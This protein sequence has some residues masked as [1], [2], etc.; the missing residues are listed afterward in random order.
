MGVLVICR[1]P[2]GIPLAPCGV[3]LGSLGRLGTPWGLCWGGWSLRAPWAPH[4]NAFGAPWDP[5]RDPQ[6]PLA[7]SSGGYWEPFGVWSPLRHFSFPWCS[8]DTP[9]GC[10][11]FLGSRDPL[12][13]LW[14]S[15]R[16]PGGLLGPLG[17]PCTLLGLFGNPLGDTP[18]V[19]WGRWGIPAGSLGAP[20]NPL[21]PLG[22]GLGLS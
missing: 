16:A 3:P 10:L 19:P 17:V 13:A 7:S 5:L 12:G 11:G 4:G 22:K 18:R 9:R 1:G 8:L 14:E 20:W 15:L 2:R 6:G 21:G